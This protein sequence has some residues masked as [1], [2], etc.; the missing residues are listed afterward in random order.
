MST[1]D[2]LESLLALEFQ[3]GILIRRFRRTMTDRATLV[4]EDLSTASYVIL[5]F[6]DSKGPVRSSV[7]V[8]TFMLDKGAVSRQVQQLVDLGLVDRRPDPDDGRAQ[9]VGVTAEG[10]RRAAAVASARRE[11]LDERLGDWSDADLADL[12]AKLSRYNDALE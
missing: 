12:V 1:E 5:A 4:H 2:R 6:L 9:I 11:R 7:I 3:F 10:A 8:E